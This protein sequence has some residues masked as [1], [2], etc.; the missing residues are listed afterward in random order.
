MVFLLVRPFS[1]KRGCWVTVLLWNAGVGLGDNS[2]QGTTT[3]E[4]RGGGAAGGG[5]S[6]WV[7]HHQEK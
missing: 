4:Q 5:S 6:A 2:K 1:G 7:S 3:R